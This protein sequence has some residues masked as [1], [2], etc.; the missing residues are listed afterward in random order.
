LNDYLTTHWL[1]NS[2]AMMYCHFG[3]KPQPELENRIFAWV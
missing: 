2:K 1:W 3:E